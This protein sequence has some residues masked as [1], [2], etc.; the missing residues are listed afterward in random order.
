V[1]Q[2][3]IYAVLLL[4]SGGLLAQNKALA[5]VVQIKGKSE[6]VRG[7]K[8]IPAKV[9]ELIQK[10]DLL[11]THK[12]AS[13]SVQ[14]SSGAM[15]KMAADTEVML[16]DLVRDNTGFRVKLDVRRGSLA[17]KIDQ[18]GGKD[19]YTV[20]APTAVAG[21]RGTE[22]LVEINE[23]VNQAT[24][25][26]NDGSVAV[27]DPA[28]KLPEEVCEEGNKIVSD[29]QQMKETLLEQFEKDKM[30]IFAE[31]SRFKQQNFEQLVEQIRKNRE[32]M[33]QHRQQMLQ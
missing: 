28:G 25:L 26:V 21:V 11:R 29:G 33:D 8:T 22:F 15:F 31:M 4:S 24:V 14:L 30:A 19:N 6:I 23:A 7:G 1:K 20:Q 27:Q 2:I 17:N 12:D 32:M 5:L 13:V 16:A 3:L 9:N 18:M 10:G